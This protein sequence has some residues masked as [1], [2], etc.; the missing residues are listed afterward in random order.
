MVEQASGDRYAGLGGA[1]G[2]PAP[3][4]TGAFYSRWNGKPL[5]FSKPGSDAVYIKHLSDCCRAEQRVEGSR[6]ET[7]RVV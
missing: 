6:L 5:M 4:G 7:G 3:L 2:W 1:G